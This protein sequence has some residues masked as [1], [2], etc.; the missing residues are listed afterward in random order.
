MD[1]LKRLVGL[2]SKE[3]NIHDL[4]AEDGATAFSTAI[5]SL[6]TGTMYLGYHDPRP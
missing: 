1:L 2:I 6:N 3:D 5:G 4:P